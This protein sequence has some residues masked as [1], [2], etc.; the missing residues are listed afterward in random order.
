MKAGQRLLVLLLTLSAID[1]T[2]WAVVVQN[3]RKALYP[4]DADS[5]VI[6]ILDTVILST[7][8]LPFLLL[9]WWLPSAAFFD[10]LRRRGTVGGVCMNGL[11]FASYLPAVLFG[12]GGVAYWAVPNH[13]WIASSYVALLLVLALFAALDVRRVVAGG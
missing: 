2:T 12:L 9:V 6:P 13:Y 7:L 5:I 3:Q 1:G 4:V 10:R 11:L 8:V